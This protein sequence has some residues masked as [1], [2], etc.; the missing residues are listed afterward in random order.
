[1]RL[2]FLKRIYKKLTGYFLLILFLGYFGSITFFPHTHIVDGVTIVHSH[3]YKSQPGNV[4]VNHNH[5][6]NGFLLIQFISNFIAIAPILFI[7]VVIIRN[8]FN[9]RL[10]IQGENLILN[11]YRY[12]THRPR[13]PTLYLH[14]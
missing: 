8:T 7:G 9:T 10:L 11:L 5:S 14:N 2:D 6:K 13:A 12:S 3:P 1:M 4:P